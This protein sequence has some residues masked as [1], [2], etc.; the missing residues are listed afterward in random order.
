MILEASV[1]REKAAQDFAVLG[2]DEKSWPP[3]GL[4]G[5]FS[6]LAGGAQLRTKSFC[7]LS[8]FNCGF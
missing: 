5:I 4:M 8:R 2:E 1:E 6:V 7:R 3:I